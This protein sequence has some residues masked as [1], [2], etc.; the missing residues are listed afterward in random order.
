[1][2]SAIRGAHDRTVCADRDYIL[3][4]DGVEVEK[5]LLGSRILL[6]PGR[7]AVL[8]LHDDAVFTDD[9]SDLSRRRETNRIQ[10]AILEKIR[11]FTLLDSALQP[12]LALIGRSQQQALRADDEDTVVGF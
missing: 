1:M 3:F 2:A 7:A 6:G 11:T 12:T 5:V 10:V 9:P 8:G 4:I